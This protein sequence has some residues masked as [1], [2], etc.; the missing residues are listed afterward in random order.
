MDNISGKNVLVFGAAGGM[1]MEI[2]KALLKCGVAVSD[3]YDTIFF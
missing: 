3:C 1:G 2:N